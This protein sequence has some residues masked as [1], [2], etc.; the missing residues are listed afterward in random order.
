MIVNEAKLLNSS[1]QM[2]AKQE[3]IVAAAETLFLQQGYGLTSMDKIA[4]EAKVTKQ[5]VYRY[6]SSKQI[7]FDAVIEHH[8]NKNN[9]VYTFDSGTVLEELTGYGG[10]ILAFHLQTNSLGFYRLMI[11]EGQDENLMKSF[12][13]NGPNK[14]MQPLITFL[15][16]Y[17]SQHKDIEFKAQMFMSMVLAPRNQQLMSS[18]TLITK[19]QQQQH[20]NK[21]VQLFINMIDV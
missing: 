19:Q 10:F 8:R 15:K 9:A 20:I 6:F 12:L 5:T 13:S 7:L 4:L 2:E 11:R 21:V 17:F 1:P 3:I 18:K 14:V 16:Q